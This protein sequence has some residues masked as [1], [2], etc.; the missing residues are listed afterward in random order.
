MNRTFPLGIRLR[1]TGGGSMQRPLKRISAA[2]RVLFGLAL[3]GKS[4][5][6]IHFR[7]HRRQ[8]NFKYCFR[9]R[10][11]TYTIRSLNSGTGEEASVTQ[12]LPSTR[13]S[14]RFTPWLIL[15]TLMAFSALLLLSPAQAS[16][17]TLPVTGDSYTQQNPP[18]ANTGTGGNLFVHG[19]TTADR[20]AYIQFSLTPL[21]AGLTSSNVAIATMKLFVNIVTTTGTFDVHL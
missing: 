11:S 16:A 3:H 2:L 21:P 6:S 7:I 14:S 8:R 12:S 5:C 20:N 9:L 19:S 17:Q 10:G 15:V 1:T 13:P 18:N 4:R